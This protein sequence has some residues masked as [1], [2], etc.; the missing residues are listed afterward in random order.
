M[1]LGRGGPS[2]PAPSPIATSP[3]CEAHP[4]NT[5]QDFRPLSDRYELD[6]GPCSYANGFA[7]IDTT[8]DAPYYGYR[9]L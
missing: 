6:C 4:M 2:A 5:T 7:Q 1:R 3:T 9:P 8:Q